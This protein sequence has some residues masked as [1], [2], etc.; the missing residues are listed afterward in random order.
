MRSRSPSDSS[1]TAS[2]SS[3]RLVIDDSLSLINRTGAYFIAREIVSMF[4]HEATVRRWRLLADEMPDGFFLRLAR[5]LMRLELQ[6]AHSSRF[7]Q[8]PRTDAGVQLFLDPLYVLRAQIGAGDIVLC[9]DVG[10]LTHP[11]LYDLQ[12][13]ELYRLAYERIR[14]AK[15]GMVFVSETSLSAFVRLFGDD[16]RFLHAIPLFVRQES[17]DGAAE[18]VDGIDRP[19]FLAVGALER[20]KNHTASLTAFAMSGLAA[21]GYSLVICGSSSDAT[22]EIEAQVA[23]TPGAVLL[24]YV[25]DAQLRWLYREAAAFVLPSLLEGFGMPALEAA[26]HGLIPIVSSDSALEEAVGANGLAVP[27]QSPIDIAEAMKK[28][29]ALGPEEHQAW[30]GRLRA[31]AAGMTRQKFRADWNA[32]MYGPL[33]PLSDGREGNGA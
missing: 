5:K 2:R 11:R 33:G 21:E 14:Q 18:P 24:G 26:Q 8:W 20:R 4:G 30:S 15:P 27:G 19:F 25:S 6:F 32:L 28:I 23:A 7:L 16:F 3:D 13:V 31:H 17:V 1:E 22:V 10:P 29:S 9:H 12:T